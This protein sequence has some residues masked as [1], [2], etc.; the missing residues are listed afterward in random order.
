M[1]PAPREE[2]SQNTL[3]LR[4]LTSLSLN[5]RNERPSERY[6][7]PAQ[8]PGSRR[9]SERKPRGARPFV[10]ADRVIYLRAFPRE[11][12]ANR[13]GGGGGAGRGP[14]RRRTGRAHTRSAE[15]GTANYSAALTKIPERSRNV[16]A[17]RGHGEA[18]RDSLPNGLEG[19][20][21][22]HTLLNQTEAERN[23]AQVLCT[24]AA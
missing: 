2:P 18:D 5:E 24:G 11:P 9:G 14:E 23:T 12:G 4:A 15:G 8:H 10:A 13:R 21:P 6:A 17:F 20:P 7:G 3:P 1:T 16:Y 22:R 19:A